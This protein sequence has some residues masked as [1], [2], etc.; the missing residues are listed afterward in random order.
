MANLSQGNLVISFA[1]TWQ[2]EKCI[3]TKKEFVFSHLFDFTFL[4][5]E[6]KHTFIARTIIA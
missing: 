6:N 3:I 4:Q 2:A 1:N 5:L